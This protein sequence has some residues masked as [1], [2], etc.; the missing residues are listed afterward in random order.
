M[1]GTAAIPITALKMFTVKNWHFFFSWKCFIPMAS[2]RSLHQIKAGR[3]AYGAIRSSSFFDGEVYDA[4]KE[5]P[6]WSTAT[7]S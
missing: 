3:L 2:A 4:R 6:N 5:K 7:Y 1:A